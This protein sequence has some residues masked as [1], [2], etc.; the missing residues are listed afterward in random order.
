M[1]YVDKLRQ[2]LLLDNHSF[3]KIQQIFHSFTNNKEN[4]RIKI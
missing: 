3:S 4:D 1:N 2:T